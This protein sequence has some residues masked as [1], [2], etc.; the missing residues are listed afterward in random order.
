ME[1]YGLATQFPDVNPIELLWDGDGL[2]DPEHGHYK[3]SAHLE[4]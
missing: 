1:N 2:P 4:K 3:P